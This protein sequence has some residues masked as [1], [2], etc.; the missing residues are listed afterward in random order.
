MD[1]PTT[2]NRQESRLHQIV[3]KPSLVKYMIQSAFGMTVLLISAMQVTMNPHESNEM[4][5]GLICAI[6]GIFLPNPTPEG[7]GQPE[8]SGPLDIPATTTTTIH[9]RIT[10]TPKIKPVR[11]PENKRHAN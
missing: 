3:K 7:I 8:G 10:S 2:L 9:E 11:L 1:E 5:I 4:W 6:V